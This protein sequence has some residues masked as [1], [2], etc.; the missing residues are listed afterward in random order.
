MPVETSRL[1]PATGRPRPAGQGA[2]RTGR[3]RRFRRRCNRPNCPELD[4]P[5]RRL[6]TFFLRFFTWWNSQT[7]GTQLWT[8]R[9]GAFVG[10]DELGNRYFRTKGGRIDPML[11]FER[12]WCDIQGHRRSLLR[13]P[14]VAR[15][16]APYGR[17]VADRGT[18]DAAQLVKPHRPNLTGTPGAHRPTGSTLAQG[19]RPK[20]TGDYKAWPT[21]RR[22]ARKAPR[23]SH[24]PFCVLTRP[25]PHYRLA[26]VLIAVAFTLGPGSAVAQ[27]G[28]IFGA[29][30]RPPAAVPNGNRQPMPAD[31]PVAAASAAYPPPSSG[32]AGL[33]AVQSQPPAAATRRLGG[34]PILR[35]SPL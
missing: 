33:G 8:A 23:P 34:E 22:R 28:S 29:P 27:F 15:L 35:A 31:P 10:E 13:A 24:A 20:A 2:D 9:F 16:A 6:K 12:R 11:G 26:A 4:E 30:P 14:V 25:M 32:Q 1:W 7:F 21:L 19:R 5:E 3:T 17:R 18:S